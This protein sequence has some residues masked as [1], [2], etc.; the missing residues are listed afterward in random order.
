MGIGFISFTDSLDFST[1]SGKLHF[2]ILSAF[3]QF[4]RDL[5]RER[6]LSA[7]QR[8]KDNGYKFTGRPKGS[9]DRKKRKTDGYFAIKIIC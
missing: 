4:E 8:L 9:K 6:T 7:I 2:T 5:I 3:S 1:A